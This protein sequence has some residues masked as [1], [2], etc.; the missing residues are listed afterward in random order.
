LPS[1]CRAS[2]EGEADSPA[3]KGPIFE[4]DEAEGAS[5]T[6]KSG[7]PDAVARRSGAHSNRAR[8]QRVTRRAEHRHDEDLTR[9]WNQDGDFLHDPTENV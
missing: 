9:Q 8:A 1:S 6:S 5:V 4:E 2:G 7:V 3:A